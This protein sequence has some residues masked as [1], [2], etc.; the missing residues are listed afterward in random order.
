MWAGATAGR[1]SQMTGLRMVYL[2]G[3]EWY[4]LRDEVGE[5]PSA[6]EKVRREGA[7]LLWCQVSRCMLLL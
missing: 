4:W 1:L 6:A 5:E 3:I 7:R 2:D